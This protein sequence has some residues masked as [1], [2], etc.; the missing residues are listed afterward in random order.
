MANWVRGEPVDVV[1]GEE[2]EARIEYVGPDT[3][4]TEAYLARIVARPAFQ[5][6]AER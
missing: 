5:R 3:P 2:V 4:R 6:A 1:A